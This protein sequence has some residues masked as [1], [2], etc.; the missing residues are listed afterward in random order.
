MILF[1]PHLKYVNRYYH[2]LFSYHRYLTKHHSN[3]ADWVTGRKYWSKLSTRYLML[4]NIALAI[5]SSRLPYCSMASNTTM[6]SFISLS[7]S[8]YLSMSSTCSNVKDRF[9]GRKSF[10]WFLQSSLYAIWRNCSSWSTVGGLRQSRAMISARPPVFYESHA[11]KY[12]RTGRSTPVVKHRGSWE[13][14]G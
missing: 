6:R 8:M 11:N 5:A 4:F 14:I 7:V 1:V 9:G 2:A 3:S 12:E 13:T 10:N